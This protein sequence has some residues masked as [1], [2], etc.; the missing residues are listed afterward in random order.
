MATKP[1]EVADV[2]HHCRGPLVVREDDRPESVR[3]R[4]QAYAKRTAPPADYYRHLGLL[5]TIPADG[6]P[7]E[8]HRRT[9][10]ALAARAWLDTH[11]GCTMAAGGAD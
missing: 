5:V 1:P 10:T 9:V 8:I 2:C 6:T 4:M 7:D 3:V 11:R